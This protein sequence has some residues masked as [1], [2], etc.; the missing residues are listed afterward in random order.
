MN[1]VAYRQDSELKPLLGALGVRV[2]DAELKV[3]SATMDADGSGD[4]SFD[5]F[6]AWFSRASGNEGGGD[7]TSDADS[8]TPR[9]ALDGPVSPRG[10]TT[11]KGLKNNV[12]SR[13]A[14][15]LFDTELQC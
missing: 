1:A 3:A 4:V 9:S 5:E 13:V 14:K 10:A 12:R 2:A 7:D 15:V 11:V 8:R 6:Y